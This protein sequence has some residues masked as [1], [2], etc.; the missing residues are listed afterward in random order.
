[1]LENELLLK[2]TNYTCMISDGEGSFDRIG[3]IANPARIMA[4]QI[5]CAEILLNPVI[6]WI[7]LRFLVI[8]GITVVTIYRYH[9]TVGK[10]IPWTIRNLIPTSIRVRG[11]KIRINPGMRP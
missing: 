6:E 5:L 2:T 1:M 11:W 10:Q 7:V 4:T 3:T 9:F 8:M